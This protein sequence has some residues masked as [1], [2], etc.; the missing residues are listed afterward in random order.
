MPF[1]QA[2]LQSPAFSPASSHQKNDEVYNDLLQY[3]GVSDLASL[4]KVPFETLSQANALQVARSNYSSYTYKPVL[5]GSYVPGPPGALLAAGK[6]NKDLKLLLANNADEGLLFSNPAMQNMEVFDQFV[7]A[8]APTF[9]SQEI[10]TITAQLYP[11][12]FNGTY[13]YVD[14]ITRQAAILAELIVTCNKVYLSNAFD[15]RTSAYLFALLPALHSQDVPYTYY[16][17]VDQVQGSVGAQTIAVNVAQAIQ[18][19]LTTFAATGQPTYSQ[20]ETVAQWGSTANMLTLNTTGFT[21]EPD[22]AANPR[23]RFW[24]SMQTELDPK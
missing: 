8:L 19:I 2:I 3:A 17:G 18:E 11:P 16:N 24:Q 5:N 6:F 22:S 10:N 9:F 12:V 7:I 15:N 20:G 4:R 13:G 23:C 14:E 21:E 1:Q